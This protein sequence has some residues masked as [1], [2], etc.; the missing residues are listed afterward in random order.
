MAE[1]G[2][3]WLQGPV[4]CRVHG[5]PPRVADDQGRLGPP[6]LG[7]EEFAGP[8]LGL[9][10]RGR[11][12]LAHLQPLHKI[13]DAGVGAHVFGE[14][15]PV[16][17]CEV[18]RQL[19]MLQ[20]GADG[21]PGPG[22]QHRGQLPEVAKQQEL[23]VGVQPHARQ[24]R[25]ERHVQLGDLLNHEPVKFLHAP[26]ADVPAHPVVGRLRAEPQVLRRAMRLRH[27]VHRLALLTEPPRS[28][29]QGT[30]SR[31]PAGR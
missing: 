5:H 12:G 29:A 25:P 9:L 7:G 17:A 30:S 4:G 1:P 15:V 13:E 19:A 6:W 11:V 21:L 26:V 14:L 20:R 18:Q 28:C 2:A 22:V 16:A 31:C 10:Q 24:V 8:R 27:Q 3:R 23:H